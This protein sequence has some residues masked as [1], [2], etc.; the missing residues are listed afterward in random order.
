MSD[1]AAAYLLP[2]EQNERI[3]QE[4]I[5]PQLL[6]GRTSQDVPTVV[7]LVGQ[8]GSGKS[9]VGN[10]IAQKL[11]QQGGFIDVDSD[12]Y[13]PLHPQYDAL[14]Q[15]DD[16]LMAACTRADGRAWM[17]K[18]HSYVREHKLNAV[19]QET[20]QDGAAVADTMRQ[21]RADGFRVEM[22]TLGVSDAMSNQGIVNRYHEQ[23][24]DRGSGR[25]TVQKNADQSY[26]GILDLAELVDQGRLADEVAVFRRGEGTPRYHNAL[27]ERGQWQ[28]PPRLNAAIERERKRR[29]T[30]VE[31]GDFLRTQGKLR[32]EMDADWAPKLDEIDDQA[33]PRLSPLSL[34]S[35]SEL[36]T[37]RAR[38][39]T[40]V[41]AV[42]QHASSISEPPD[43]SQ[44]L[45]ETNAP[46]EIL[47]RAAR[48][49]QEDRQH[50]SR[51]ADQ[52]ARQAKSLS[53]Q[54]GN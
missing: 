2:A 18:A 27:D 22:L 8:P 12:L 52:A 33:T 37:R 6:S 11:D 19:I 21:Y 26:T 30:E 28:A 41:D 3:F 4:R 42:Q 40:A 54:Q 35:D 53:R 7:F 5:V 46:P 31:S 10:L 13:K 36:E 50:A 29:W 14:M 25:L 34:L 43:M 32:T 17:A 48:S 1:E 20:S 23:V 44:L 38:L 39:D 45:R 47:E 49:A 9:R 51:Q 16:T 15:R 24:L